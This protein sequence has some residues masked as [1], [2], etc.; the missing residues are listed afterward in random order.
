[1]IYCNYFNLG[2]IETLII[3]VAITAVH[4]EFMCNE[5]LYMHVEGMSKNLNS[6]SLG[7]EFHFQVMSAKQVLFCWRT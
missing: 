2:Y 6:D 1:V 7:I 4:C 5:S 3:F